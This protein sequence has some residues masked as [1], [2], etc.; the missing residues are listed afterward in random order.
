MTIAL[1]RQ[2]NRILVAIVAGL[3]A[4]GLLATIVGVT[5]VE[6]ASPKACKV[7]NVSR[8]VSYPSLAAAV[9]RARN[10]NKLTVRGICKGRTTI[11][12]KRLTIVGV[13]TKTSGMPTLLSNGTARVLTIKGPTAD[14]TLKRI[15]VKGDPRKLLGFEGGGI[16]V[17]RGKVTL[18]DVKVRGFNVSRRGGGVSLMR[19]SITLLGA[20]AIRNNS[21]RGDGGGIHAEGAGSIRLKDTSTI[22]LNTTRIDGGGIRTEGADVM[23]LGASSITGNLASGDG[24]GGGIYADTESITMYGAS[25]IADNE[26]RLGGGI[27]TQGRLQMGTTTSITGN[28]GRDGS[29]G[30]HAGLGYTPIGVV[31]APA[32]DANVFGNSPD[33]CGP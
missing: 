14:V 11:Q 15:A 2:T 26:A 6:A 8:G 1:Q 33:D 25:S 10:G 23:L 7:R 24:D 18:R 12:D 19:G 30:I 32:V 3:L 20:T 4:A 22:K 17:V 21:A 31:C 16:R 13:R 5:P 9:S 29:G 28:S 27:R